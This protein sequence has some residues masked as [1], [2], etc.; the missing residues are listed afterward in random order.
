MLQ[1]VNIHILYAADYSLMKAM[2]N[3]DPTTTVT[4]STLVTDTTVT[5]IVA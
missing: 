4:K 3:F 1:C 2:F 5:V